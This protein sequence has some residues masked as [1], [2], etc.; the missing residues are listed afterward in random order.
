M[1]GSLHLGFLMSRLS[2]ASDP[3]RAPS[4]LYIGVLVYDLRLERWGVVQDLGFPDGEPRQLRRAWLRPEGGGRE[5]NPLYDDLSPTAP[6]P[7][8]WDDAL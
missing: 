2:L 3:R 7:A 8:L 4:W 5:W 6:P 1:S